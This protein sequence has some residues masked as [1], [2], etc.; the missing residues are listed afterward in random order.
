MQVIFESV[1]P[2]AGG[3]TDNTTETT[4]MSGRHLGLM[5]VILQDPEKVLPVQ[6]GSPVWTGTTEWSHL[7]L[8]SEH[9]Q[10]LSQHLTPLESPELT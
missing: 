4:G 7:T 10:E 8:D 3:E 2:R 5:R 1:P 6:E 9:L